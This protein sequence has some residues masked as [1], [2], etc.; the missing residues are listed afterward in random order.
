MQRQIDFQSGILRHRWMLLRIFTRFVS[1]VSIIQSLVTNVVEYKPDGMQIV[2]DIFE[3][4][5]AV[6]LLLLDSSLVTNLRWDRCVLRVVV[7][8]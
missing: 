6:L 2:E 7:V 5:A 3:Q 1:K 4:I 8:P